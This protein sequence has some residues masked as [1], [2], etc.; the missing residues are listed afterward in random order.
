MGIFIHHFISPFSFVM[1]VLWF[2]AFALLGL[3]MRKLKF[4]IKFSVVPLLLLFVL[5]VLRMFLAIEIPGATIIFS[6]TI[7]P[8]IVDIFRFEIV[9]VQIFGFPINVANGCNV[10]HI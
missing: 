9:P 3:L 2:N 4:P 6:E 10:S 7:Y 1:G 8:A 5:S